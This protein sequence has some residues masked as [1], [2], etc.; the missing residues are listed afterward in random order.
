MQHV[1][2]NEVKSSTIIW[3]STAHFVPNACMRYEPRFNAT[4]AQDAEIVQG[5]ERL[6]AKFG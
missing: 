3:K 5:Q 2:F 4:R 1:V 6:P